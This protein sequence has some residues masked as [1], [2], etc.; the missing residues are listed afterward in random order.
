M[1]REKREYMHA[2]PVVDRLTC[3]FLCFFF[4]TDHRLFL[5][6]SLLLKTQK[7]YLLLL[8][9]LPIKKGG[10]FASYVKKEQALAAN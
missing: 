2:P 4:K 8:L 1:C 7:T 10:C 3:E 5:P 9:M 6:L